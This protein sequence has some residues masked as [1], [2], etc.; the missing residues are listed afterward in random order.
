MW[1]AR[2]SRK[3]P[4][5][6]RNCAGKDPPGS[7]RPPACSGRT[8]FSALRRAGSRARARWPPAL[9]G[10]IG[11]PLASSHRL[12][13]FRPS[14]N[15]LDTAAAANQAVPIPPAC[16]GNAVPPGECRSCAVRF[17]PAT[18]PPA[19]PCPAWGRCERTRALQCRDVAPRRDAPR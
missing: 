5:I 2:Y 17:E 7:R 15:S 13:Q 12:V 11:R 14:E 16:S 18:T 8:Q 3:L 9:G 6:G 4:Q 10:R 19:L 1:P